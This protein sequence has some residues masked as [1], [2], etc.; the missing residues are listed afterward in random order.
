MKNPEMPSEIDKAFL[1]EMFRSY[2]S[3]AGYGLFT[4][5]IDAGVVMYGCV[6]V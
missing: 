5:K 2:L 6:W 3:R 1:V 4:E